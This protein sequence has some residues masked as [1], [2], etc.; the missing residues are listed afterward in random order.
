MNNLITNNDALNKYANALG[1]YLKKIK[2]IWKGLVKK[3]DE[4]FRYI[5]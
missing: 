1:K 5:C 4:I 3:W 2:N